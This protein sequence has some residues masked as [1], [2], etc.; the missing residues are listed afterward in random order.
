MTAIFPP[1]LCPGMPGGSCV[2]LREKDSPLL[3]L[4]RM[5]NHFGIIKLARSCSGTADST[6]LRS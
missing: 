2:L 4:P 6:G 3:C 1:H 5:P